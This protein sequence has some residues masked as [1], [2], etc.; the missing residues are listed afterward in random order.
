MTIG[1]TLFLWGT[2]LPVLP[3]LYFAQKSACK[4]KK[5][6]IVGV[7][8]PYEAQND[9]SVLALLE[10]YKRELGLTAWGFLA[11]VVPSLFIRS[12]GVFMTFWFIWTILLCV[13]FFI[14][15]IRC[16]K[17]LRR[18]KEE[19]GWKRDDAP[20]VVTDLRAAAEE[21]RWIS[22]LWFLPPFLLSLLPLCFDR[23]FW[24]LWILDAALIPA[25]YACYRWLYRNRADVVDDDTHRTLALTRIR[26]YNWGKC[27]LILA[28]A[29]GAF[30]VGLW[31][32]LGHIWLLMAVI[33]AYSLVVCIAVIG[34]EF[35]VRRL[36]E[37]LTEGSGRG[38]YVDEDD[39]WIWGMLYYN[40]DDTRIMINDRVGMNT[41]LNL[42]RRP[43]QV[44]MGLCL[45]L[46]LA[47]PLFGVWI[48][49]DER[50]PV[51]LELTETELTGSHYGRHWSVALADIQ[52][53]ELIE[54][55]PPLRRRAGTGLDNAMTGAYS[56]DEW[57][58]LT[59]CIDPRTGP[60]LLVTQIDGKICLFGSSTDG[61]TERIMSELNW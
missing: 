6:I 23:E 10:R 22:P 8:L 28:W 17:A 48:I 1:W 36:Q 19:R 20:Q 61:E 43:A 46:L 47:C 25:F 54:E 55:L 32:A 39:R 59:C 7:T 3:I 13:I 50:A 60:W 18:L 16:N 15:Y 12:F 31:L 27:W 38:Y 57:G 42:A 34:I 4:P 40:P 2:A 49:G 30:N 21:M 26:R 5:N 52:S 11:A 41:S 35:R 58:R 37:K 14:P 33:L 29:T 56:S 53:A 24:W 44:I 51:E 45:A 9:P